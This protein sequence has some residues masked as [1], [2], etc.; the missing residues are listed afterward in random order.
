MWILLSNSDNFIMANM[1]KIHKSIRK[2]N[3]INFTF[4]KFTA[5]FTIFKKINF[6]LKLIIRIII[7]LYHIQIH[8]HKIHI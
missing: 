7:L 3:K 4:D 6:L 8:H 2:N 1:K 5:K